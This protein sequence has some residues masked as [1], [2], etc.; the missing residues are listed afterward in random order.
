MHSVLFPRHPVI[1]ALTLS[2][3]ASALAKGV[4]Y[5]VSALYFTRVAGLSA[6]MVGLGLTVAGGAGVAGSFLTGR[7]CDVFGA[8]RVLLVSSG[9][10]AVALLL[11]PAARTP[12]VF[13]VIACAAVGLQAAQSTARTTVMAVA[14]PGPDRV[15]VRAR[16]RVVVNVFI[17]LGSVLAG[18]ALLIG[19]APAYTTAVV[20]VG[21]LNAVSC[22]PLWLLRDI[23]SRPRED[24]APLPEGGSPLRDPRY[25]LVTALNGV[26]AMHFGLTSVGIPLW[27]AARTQAPTV[28][29]SVLLVLNTVLV[30][31]L[32][33][34][35][36]RGTDDIP[37][38][39]RAVGTA[40]LLLA[41]ACAL[42]AAAALAGPAVAVLVLVLGAVAHAFAEMRG[43]AGSWGLAFELADPRRPGAYQ[44]VSQTGYALG[45][46]LAPLV[47][48]ATAIRHGSL[49][50]AL[51][52]VLF[53][54]AG[55]LTMLVTASARRPVAIVEETAG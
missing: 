23:G 41:L 14:F 10:V 46:M 34:R 47:V 9:G 21:L 36:S 53:V 7:L 40:G 2:T 27:V 49:G 38:A 15:A 18:A 35:V 5:T 17:G 45:G 24:V 44:G 51:L 1:R 42:Y 31:L 13:T 39:A 22:V 43:E 6:T 52:A 29:V 16:I 25:L 37:T 28:V 48:T 26:M 55:G 54:A 11:Y 20:A 4:F 3:M 50:W 30:A 32:Q 19:T 12:P 8:G 33:V